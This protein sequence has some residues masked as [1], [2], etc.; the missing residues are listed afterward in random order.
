MNVKT[1]Y[2]FNAV[3]GC[4]FLGKHFQL[5]GILNIQLNTAIKYAIITFYGNGPHIYF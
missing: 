1:G 2:F 3:N 5:V 4:K